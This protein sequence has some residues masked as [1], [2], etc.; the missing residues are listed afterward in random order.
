[1]PASYRHW[2]DLPAEAAGRSAFMRGVILHPR[3]AV[4]AEEGEGEA[5][6]DVEAH[7]LRF[8]VEVLRWHSCGAAAP[9]SG[10]AARGPEARTRGRG[11]GERQKRAVRRVVAHGRACTSIAPA[12]SRQKAKGERSGEPFRLSWSVARRR[13]P[14]PLIR[15]RYPRGRVDCTGISCCCRG[16]SGKRFGTRAPPP[17]AARVPLLSRANRH[18]SWSVRG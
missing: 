8:K 6:R 12:S 18:A 9:N 3:V 11:T 7:P 2:P 13:A 14:S 10:F 16:T 5:R 15:G 4:P 1:M 17:L